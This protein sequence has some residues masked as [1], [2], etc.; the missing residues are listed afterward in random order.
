MNSPPP[1]PAM[2]QMRRPEE[3]GPELEE[4]IVDYQEHR[5]R[6]MGELAS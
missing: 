3:V 4:I 2:H 6:K 1:L 5:A